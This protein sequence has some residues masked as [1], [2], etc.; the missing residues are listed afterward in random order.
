MKRVKLMAISIL[1][2]ILLLTPLYAMAVEIEEDTTMSKQETE[3]TYNDNEI[4]DELD[5]TLNETVDITDDVEK[6]TKQNVFI[7]VKTKEETGSINDQTALTQGWITFIVTIKNTSFNDDISLVFLFTNNETGEVTKKTLN[8]IDNFD[9]G[10]L[11]LPYGEY[12]VSLEDEYYNQF[13]VYNESLNVN[14]AEQKYEVSI[15]SLVEKESEVQN[16]EEKTSVFLYLLKNNIFFLIILIGCGGFLL[17][18]EIQKRRE[19]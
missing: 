5:E 11:K 7:E 10:T 1:A 9:G 6:E 19:N 12:T 4:E 16:E 3:V 17:Y 8:S 18:R 13:I 14:V 2:S 15:N